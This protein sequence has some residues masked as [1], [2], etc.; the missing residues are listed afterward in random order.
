MRCIIIDDEPLAIK[1]LENYIKKVSNLELV[2]KF[3]NPYDA[4][5]SLMQ[6]QIDIIFLDINMPGLS[7]IQLLKSIDLSHSKVIF[8]TG[9][10]EYAIEGFNH[11]AADYLLKPFSFERFLKAVHKVKRL[12]AMPQRT[13][14]KPEQETSLNY[15]LVKSEHKIL[16]VDLKDIQY[17]EGYKDYVK[18]HTQEQRPL[19]TLK[20]IKSLEDQLVTSDFI[21][22]HKSYLISIDK[23]KEMRNGKVKV[24]DKYLPISDSYKSIFNEKVLMGRT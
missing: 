9:H 13:F 5:E 24:K 10:S 19:M 3:T 18:I 17:I 6:L 16:K 20:S 11:D 15:I 7:G 21:R 12:T 14:D 4:W 23:I 2:G 22:I 1:L 8:T